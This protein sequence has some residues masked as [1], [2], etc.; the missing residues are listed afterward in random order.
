MALQRTASMRC[1]GHNLT[2]TAAPI[3]RLERGS[4]AQNTLM[5]TEK[6]S[7]FVEHG[8]ASNTHVMSHPSFSQ[9]G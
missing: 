1:R 8:E 9:W 5:V 3:L 2:P 4:H 7:A 6:V